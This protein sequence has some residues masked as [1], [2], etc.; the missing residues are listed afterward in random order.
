MATRS[1]CLV[2]AV[3]EDALE[4]WL[5]AVPSVEV[6]LEKSIYVSNAGGSAA[7]VDVWHKEPG[8]VFDIKLFSQSVPAGGVARWEGWIALPAFTDFYW[9]ASAAGV[10]MWSSGARLLV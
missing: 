6:W 4:H 8:G 1:D 2:R 5:T 10:T 3:S 7:Q 9:Q